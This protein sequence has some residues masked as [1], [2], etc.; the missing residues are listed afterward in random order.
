MA[1][2]DFDA[3]RRQREKEEATR[4]DEVFPKSFLEETMEEYEETEDENSIN[5][6]IKTQLSKWLTI[7]EGSTGIPGLEIVVRRTGQEVW[8]IEVTGAINS[9]IEMR[10]GYSPDINVITS[11]AI[12][13]D[14]VV[15][16][17]NIPAS[18]V[19]IDE[20]NSDLPNP[21]I[22]TK[23]IPLAEVENIKRYLDNEGI[24]YKDFTNL[25]LIPHIEIR[26]I[27]AGANLDGLDAYASHINY[28]STEENT[29]LGTKP[30]DPRTY[31]LSNASVESMAADSNKR[32]ANSKAASIMSDTPLRVSEEYA[33]SLPKI[34]KGNAD[35]VHKDLMMF[36]SD[37]FKRIKRGAMKLE[38]YL[39]DPDFANALAKGKL[40]KYQETMPKEDQE[41]LDEIR[42][43]YKL[44]SDDL[45]TIAKFN[46]NLIGFEDGRELNLL[47][48]TES[49]SES[50][51]M[52]NSARRSTG[53]SMN[54]AV[55]TINGERMYVYG[56]DSFL[57][58]TDLRENIAFEPNKKKAKKI[59][60]SEKKMKEYDRNLNEALGGALIEDKV[61]DGGKH[62][63]SSKELENFA[64]DFM[65][66]DMDYDS[67]SPRIKTLINAKKKAEKGEVDTTAAV[68][69]D[70]TFSGLVV[71]S[72]ILGRKDGLDK[73]NIVPEGETVD[74]MHDLYTEVGKD[75]IKDLTAY[76]MDS[77]KARKL[78]KPG[79]MPAMY[80]SSQRA[81]ATK[82]RDGIKD[83]LEENT[84]M[85]ESQIKSALDKL[86]PNIQK[87]TK[88]ATTILMG[89]VNPKSIIELNKKGIVTLYRPK[90]DAVDKLEVEEIKNPTEKDLLEVSSYMITHPDKK[91]S[92]SSKTG[93]IVDRTVDGKIAVSKDAE[94]VPYARVNKIDT[95]GNAKSRDNMG[96]LMNSMAPG[97]ARHMDS[98]V[99]STVIEKM[100]DKGVPIVTVHDA[101]IVPVY[102]MDTLK[103]T[104]NDAVNS[105]YEY[106]G[107][108]IRVNARNNLSVE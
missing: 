69:L 75:L 37:D 83:Y 13:R 31:T 51:S 34:T 97:I 15:I 80:N 52:S 47:T 19:K 68:T 57:D 46:D 88:D 41:K 35:E 79:V 60:L 95:K 7:A 76:G 65:K 36:R 54:F 104:Y 49:L 44:N 73:V 9:T 30:F 55:H 10:G 71:T 3:P 29:E 23:G 4:I 74:E 82:L 67:L 77:H 11:S 26:N 40:Y 90:K 108:D 24:S 45:K 93:D 89:K 66:S 101:M 86:N 42:S 105:L 78:V 102:A 62:K 6:N 5:D 33:K 38:P 21:R 50:K 98:Y 94:S 107:S 27:P 16:N 72:G 2:L 32:L 96:L 12:K 64:K 25:G 92:Y 14:R 70:A 17:G 100:H 8:Q 106:T 22:S 103:D 91:V 28:H 59:E 81:R 39:E 20:D 18:T 61:I 99:A 43:K 58:N 56:G 63:Y 53:K 48:D 1:L 85:N 87:T 84:D